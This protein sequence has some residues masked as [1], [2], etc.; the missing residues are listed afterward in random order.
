MKTNL[1]FLKP[2][3][4]FSFWI[5][6]VGS[7]SSCFRVVDP[8]MCRVELW[9]LMDF[10]N[11]PRGR[12]FIHLRCVCLLSCSSWKALKNGPP[13]TRKKNPR[14]PQ[15]CMVK[16][17]VFFGCFLCWGSRFE[18]EHRTSWTGG[19]LDQKRFLKWPLGYHVS[20]CSC[21]LVRCHLKEPFARSLHPNDERN[22]DKG[23]NLTVN[24]GIFQE[25]LLVFNA[26]E[27]RLNDFCKLFSNTF[28]S[29]FFATKKRSEFL[30]PFQ[31]VA[32]WKGTPRLFQ[33]GS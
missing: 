19:F 10:K 22:T 17:P 30:G 9:I 12:R 31:N 4:I 7:K 18:W 16:T 3:H 28:W 15:F 26:R 6:T 14:E 33:G 32:F 5:C 27:K 20:F 21:W 25:K 1:W 24:P 23:E 2:N 11:I 13:E 29:N 8:R